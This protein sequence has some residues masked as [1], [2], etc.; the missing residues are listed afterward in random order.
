[1]ELRQLRH[2]VVL[3][4]ELHFGRAAA[5]LGMTQP[6][7]SQSIMRL[8]EA[9]GA[10]L[11][12]RS[13][14]QVSLTAA[15]EALREEAQIILA[16][17]GFAERAVRRVASGELDRLRVA[18]VPMSAM[19]ILPQAIRQFRKRYPHVEVELDEQPSK[20]QVNALRNGS[21]DI[22]IISR[23][24]VNTEG[25]MVRTIERSRLVAAVPAS[26]PLGRRESVKLA[27]L[28]RFP[29]VLSPQHLTPQLHAA[30]EAAC[31]R[32][33]FTPKLTQQVGQP[34]TMF[35]LVANELGIG[36]V[37][38]T[39][40]HL[41]MEGVSFVRIEDLPDT[42]YGEAAVAWVPRAVS[43]TIS[44]MIDLIEAVARRFQRVPPGLS[45]GGDL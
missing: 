22:G 40:R 24:V 17:V 10:K 8:E 44:A 23:N 11:L 6:P 29:F 7:L 16:Q 1:M 3:A 33:G 14:R 28:G 31:R 37:Q 12:D 20:L 43:P 9:L 30:L 2:F 15:G 25:L 45:E 41:K 32:A 42:F 13:S 39:A 21:L 34:Y 19:R 27:E 26:W 4:E 18:F 5:R 38:D 35:N 36:L